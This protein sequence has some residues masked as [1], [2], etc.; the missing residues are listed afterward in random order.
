MKSTRRF[1]H[2]FGN[3]ARFLL[4][5]ALFLGVVKP[6]AAIG[7]AAAS[8]QP[9][10]QSVKP[11]LLA[12]KTY[13][14]AQHFASETERIDFIR[15]WVNQNSIHL[16]DKEHDEYAFK[17]PIVLTKLWQ[18]Y[19][20][21][22]APP[23]LS[24]GPRAVAMQKILEELGIPARLVYI[25]SDNYDQVQSHTF[26]EVL[27]SATNRWEI[28]DPDFNIYYVDLRT[29][30]RLATAELIWGDLDIL[31]PQSSIVQGWEENNVVVLKQGYF[32]AMMYPAQQKNAKSVILINNN[33][34]DPA[35][36]FTDNGNIRFNTFAAR[37]YKNPVIFVNQ[38]LHCLACK[39]LRKLDLSLWFT[40]YAEAVG[41]RTS[42]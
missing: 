2:F 23:H 37:F 16:I 40:R 38:D 27:N 9:T 15:N 4:V 10:V 3:A 20:T 30:K 31:V 18:T 17:A 32:E 19:L 41:K 12:I 13:I 33:R 8:V 11:I 6:V 14:Q 35:K 28:Q 26:L 39:K 1:I 21:G 42:Q 29:Q 36:V 22:Q 34:F 24:C 5:I 7:P 25:F